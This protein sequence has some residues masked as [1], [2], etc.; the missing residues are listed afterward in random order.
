M[1]RHLN[2]TFERVILRDKKSSITCKNLYQDDGDVLDVSVEWKNYY[3]VG[4]VGEHI[5]IA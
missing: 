5:F 1:G 3:N 2:F 4:H